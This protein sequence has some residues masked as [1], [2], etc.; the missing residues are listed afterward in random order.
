MAVDR[1]VLSTEHQTP[2]ISVGAAEFG[3]V[4]KAAAPEVPKGGSDGE[5]SQI[6]GLMSLIDAHPWFQKPLIPSLER[7][8]FLLLLL[9]EQ[10]ELLFPELS[11]RF[12]NGREGGQCFKQ[13]LFPLLMVI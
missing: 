11:G 3:T 8:I 12:G 10:C 6:W 7:K 1:L 9:P 5:R 13:K 2:K 4:G